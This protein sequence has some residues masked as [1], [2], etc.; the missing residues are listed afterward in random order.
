MR[1]IFDKFSKAPMVYVFLICLVL[2]FPTAIMH[3]AEDSSSLIV[4][5][6]GIDKDSDGYKLSILAFI[7]TASSGFNEK[8]KLIQGKG[9]TISEAI[10]KLA[11]HTGKELAFAHAGIVAVGKD[12]A[13]DNLFQVMDSFFRFNNI[14]K[15]AL[16]VMVNDKAEDLLTASEKINKSVGEKIN[17]L[18]FFDENSVFPVNTNIDSLYNGIYNPSKSSLLS[19]IKV[20]KESSEGL[21]VSDECS[22]SDTDGAQEGGAESSSSGDEEKKCVIINDGDAVLIKKGRDVGFLEFCNIKALN[23]LNNKLQTERIKIKGLSELSSEDEEAVFRVETKKVS[24]L[25]KF[26][27]GKPIVYF[28]L[29]LVLRLKDIHNFVENL[30]NINS[31]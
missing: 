16:I 31:Y 20:K 1:K 17:E 18:L 6:V 5:V 13:K 25:V 27:N 23:F 29:K 24:K 12:I 7:P 2:F 21:D 28:D 22:G 26:N 10:E 19:M 3:P 30:S 11:V 15:K 9:E 4:S 14:T 8:D